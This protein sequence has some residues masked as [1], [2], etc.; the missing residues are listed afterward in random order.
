MASFAYTAVSSSGSKS[1]GVISAP[2]RAAAAAEIKRKSLTPISVTEVGGASE[3]GVGR[4]RS[5]KQ[6]ELAIAYQQVADL[7]NAGVPLLRS[8]KLVS[9]RKDA[10]A[11]SGA[12]KGLAELVEDGEELAAAMQQQEARFPYVHIAM[13]RAGEKG[14]FLES[15]LH[16]L[17]TLV[18]RQVELREKIVGASAYPAVIGTIGVL[19][20]LGLFLFFVPLFKEQ[21]VGE[22]PL[23]PV[24]RVLFFLSD[25]MTSNWWF[26]L[27]AVVTAVFLFMRLRKNVYVAEHATNIVLRM[28]IVGPLVR[29]LAVARFARTLGSLMAAGVPLLAAL[30]ITQDVVGL[31][32]MSEA[33]AHAE[34]AVRHGD[35][36]SET[37][38]SSG[39]FPPD[40]IEM[41]T[42]AEAANALDSTLDSAAQSLESKVDRQLGIALKIIE[43]VLLLV[44]GA[45]ITFVAVGLILPMFG[46]M[47]QI[48]G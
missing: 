44:L 24:S 35:S 5:I 14:G 34:D 7:L 25:A 45:A 46:L 39:L 38:G 43:P 1:T 26:G 15:S 6:R 20:M 10:P 17:S 41:M 18:L 4:G 28:P 11:L 33:I 19:L 13:V 12:F 30:R 31:R 48:S 9:N 32:R 22:V 21:L 47:N 2:T 29:D 23:P 16:R 40:L 8:L 3:S 42:V 27:A 36:L 37:L